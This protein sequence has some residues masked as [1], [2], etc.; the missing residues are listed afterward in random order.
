MDSTLSKAAPK[1]TL[2][3]GNHQEKE[4]QVSKQLDNLGKAVTSLSDVWNE[5]ERRIS[6]VLTDE[7]EPSP[8]NNVKVPVP[9]EEELVPLAEELR[10]Y[11]YQINSQK[12]R[13]LDILSR[14]EL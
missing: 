5:V 8:E 10:T 13:M 2:P 4:T 1:S 9:E 14:I 12:E 11:R 6:S 7:G 3:Y